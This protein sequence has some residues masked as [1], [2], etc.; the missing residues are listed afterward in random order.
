MLNDEDLFRC[1][2]LA[3]ETGALAMLHAENGGVIEVLIQQARE[4]GH[5]EP[6]WHARTR[7]S[8]TE[9]E[10]IQRAI[11][12]A[13]L[14]DCPLYVVHVS[15]EGSADAIGDAR[16]R[17]R[18]V[19]G[20]VCLHHLFADESDLERPDFEGAKFVFTP[21]PRG[22]RDRERLWRALADDTLSVVSTDHFPNF[23]SARRDA[24][25]GDF[26]KIPNGTG[27]IEERLMLIHEHGVRA[28][29]FSLSRM[30]QLLS[31]NPARLLGMHPKKG[32]ISVGAD[33]DLVVFDPEREM[34]ITAKGMHS[35]SDYTIYEGYEVT[36][37]PETVLVRGRTVVADGELCVKPGYGRY[38]SR[39]LFGE[40]LRNDPAA[41]P[42]G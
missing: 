21:P 25:G 33:A 19:W 27:G 10:A 39:A 26:S 18:E 31:T 40:A 35:R 20:E 2:Q 1:M 30:V 28:G 24:S 13:E 32:S 3:A 37:A 7:P 23:F 4:A 38:L 6:V 22:E 8:L 16:S 14:A 36:G 17:G 41:S 9:V 42:A 29:R 12:F 5:T 15:C 34:T 11:H